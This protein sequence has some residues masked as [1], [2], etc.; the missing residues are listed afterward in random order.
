MTDKD[1]TLED[2]LQECGFVLKITCGCGETSHQTI[3]LTQELID[4]VVKKHEALVKTEVESQNDYHKQVSENVA[5]LATQEIYGTWEEPVSGGKLYNQTALST[6][7]GRVLDRIGTAHL[8]SDSETTKAIAAEKQR[9]TNEE[10]S[11]YQVI[12]VTHKPISM[13]VPTSREGE[14]E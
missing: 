4:G 3:K 9:L 7:I 2:W 12:K 6:E 5:M 11:H 1:Q 10:D 8:T 13:K 14:T